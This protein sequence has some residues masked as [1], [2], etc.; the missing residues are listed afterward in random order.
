MRPST[1][2]S[3]PVEADVDVV[4][5]T[6]TMLRV[7]HDVWPERWRKVRV[8]SSPGTQKLEPGKQFGIGRP[9]S[10]SFTMPFPAIA[11]G[12]YMPPWWSVE[13]KSFDA[14]A[15]RTSCRQ[16]YSSAWRMNVE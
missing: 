15:T 10:L 5:A 3:V 16:R 1:P 13:S 4:P 7:P 14:S 12:Q 6:D 11:C 2:P 8:A 9:P